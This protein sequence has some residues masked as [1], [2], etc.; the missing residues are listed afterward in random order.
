[1]AVRQYPTTILIQLQP[2]IQSETNRNS[3]AHAYLQP[4]LHLYHKNEDK[5]MQHC[6]SV[7]WLGW[8]RVT[9]WHHHQQKLDQPLHLYSV[10]CCISLLH[11]NIMYTATDK[12][13]N[14]CL[15]IY[16]KT[17]KMH[18]SLISY[19]YVLYWECGKYF[20]LQSKHLQ[21][22]KFYSPCA[23]VA[24]SSCGKRL[25]ILLSLTQQ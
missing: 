3:H 21:I 14:S 9:E 1:M 5:C 8:R 17:S 16:V 11:N 10:H 22:L 4:T 25:L 13:M 20:V 2:Y 19:Y 18:V 7:P 15:D 12:I 6:M 24:N 23:I